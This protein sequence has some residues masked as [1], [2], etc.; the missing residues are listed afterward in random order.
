MTN[1]E[2]QELCSGWTPCFLKNGFLQVLRVK[3]RGVHGSSLEII[4]IPALQSSEVG[5]G[6]LT[7]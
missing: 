4:P 6:I 2:M 7:G 3:V 1:Y 5:F